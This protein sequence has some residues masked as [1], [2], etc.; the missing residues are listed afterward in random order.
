[1][2]T[3]INPVHSKES[4]MKINNTNVLSACLLTFG[5]ASNVYAIPEQE[6]ND[7]LSAAQPLAA[8]NVHTIEGMM[9]NAAELSTKDVDYF[10][11]E[12][13][14]GDVLDIDIDH[15]MF[16]SILGIFDEAGTLLRMNAYSDGI[17]AGSSSVMDAR[18]DKFVAPIS[19]RYTVGVSSVPRY[20]LNGGGIFF[21]G[22]ATRPGTYALT[23]SGITTPNKV[24]QINIEVKPGN[25]DLPPLNPRSQ[26]KIPVAIMGAAGFDVGNI[27]QATVTFG[28]SG[29]EKSLSK[30]Q[31]G[32]RD[33][34][35][36]GYMDLLC[37]FE[38]NTA[39]FKSGDIEG[40]L[41]GE[42]EGGIRFEGRALLKV[43]PSQRK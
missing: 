20:F 8:A 14:A 15:G 37:H 17:D 39:G 24:K 40:V 12:A 38:N 35:S 19:G 26:G 29:N 5:L 16:N 7:S 4:M 18:I 2:D 1:M 36:D 31:P 27:K 10:T 23:I 13:Q 22:F 25:K 6:V 42:M 21:E 9:G 41:K 32:S 43:L 30:C 28:S 11:F 33:I 34:N 3:T